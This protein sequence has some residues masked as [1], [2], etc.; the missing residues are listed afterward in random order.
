[1]ATL[2]RSFKVEALGHAVFVTLETKFNDTDHQSIKYA[3]V[4]E[5][6]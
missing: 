6:Q 5:T 4:M 1:M 3:E 2:E